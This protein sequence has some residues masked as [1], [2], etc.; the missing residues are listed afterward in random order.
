LA[1]FIGTAMLL[2]AVVGSGIAAE[3]LSP[4]DSGLQLLEAALAAGFA[5]I[6]IIL[7]LQPISGAHINP[8]VTLAERFTGGLT[9]R[10]TVG[11]LWVQVSGAVVGT[12]IA[13][14]MF[15]LPAIEISTTARA[16]AGTFLGEVVA[17]FGLLLLIFAMV[18]T[19][20]GMFI[21]FGVGLYIGGA[22]FFTS[23]TSFA[24]PAVTAARTLTDTFTGIAPSSALP[25][26]AAQ[27]VGMGLAIGAIYGLFPR[28]ETQNGEV[29]LE[30]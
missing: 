13:N 15:E 29:G 10:E 9:T 14:L 1:E 27:L 8:A 5:L 23:S 3:R 7:T 22:Y 18:R 19:G 12:I 20:R 28:G 2:I 30:S 24:N 16:G 21:A 6:A 17:T 26:I 4:T 11:Y 25:F